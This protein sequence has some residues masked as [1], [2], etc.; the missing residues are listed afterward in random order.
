MFKRPGAPSVQQ[1]FKPAFSVIGFFKLKLKQKG[2]SVEISWDYLNLQEQAA[3]I[4]NYTVYYANSRKQL[5]LNKGI[6]KSFFFH[7]KMI[8]SCLM[9]FHMDQLS[10]YVL[11]TYFSHLLETVLKKKCDKGPKILNLKSSTVRSVDVCKYSH[12]VVS[13]VALY[14]ES[15]LR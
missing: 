8:I 6:V 10:E 2:S 4:R 11:R 15:C 14:A 7:P 3:F 1:Y 12:L 9:S 13:L 5:H